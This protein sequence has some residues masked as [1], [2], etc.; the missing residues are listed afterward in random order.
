MTEMTTKF[1]NFEFLANVRQELSALGASAERYAY[2][3][4]PSALVK[5]R[6]D[7]K[8]Y[9]RQVE[10][11]LS[12]LID[13]S[14]ALKKIRQGYPVTEA[15]LA[16][17]ISMVLT[18]NPHINLDLLREFYNETALPLEFIIRSLVGMEPDV[19][20]S[21]FEHFAARHPLSAKQTR[22]MGLL[23][24]HIAR[25]GSV[26]LERLCDGPFTLV[27]SDGLKGVFGEEEAD[28]LIQIIE[29][30]QPLP[31]NEQNRTY[32]GNANI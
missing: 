23:Q 5:L 21:R 19:V 9:E 27:D 15:D 2:D 11:V 22:F 30:F 10:D 7:M 25:F 29:T 20:N 32:Q 14:P 8:A 26:E 4:P 1:L 12:K 31:S 3:D 28:E 16:S 6:V 17:L 18:Q 24:N 13:S